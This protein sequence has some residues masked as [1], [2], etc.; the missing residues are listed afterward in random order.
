MKIAIVGAGFTGL[1]A[2]Y[3]LSH[4]KHK[5][6]I[7]EKEATV[8]GLASGFKLKEWQWTVEKHYHHWFTS[9]SYAINLIKELGLGQKLIFPPSVTS[10][11]YGNKIYPF[12]SPSDFMTF[13]H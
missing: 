7:F 2:A 6:T 4:R 8:G 3:V 9:D 1:S 11:F 12:N 13:S 10:I 5:I